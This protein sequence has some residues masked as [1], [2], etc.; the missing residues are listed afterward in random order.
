MSHPDG[1]RPLPIRGRHRPPRHGA[2]AGQPRRRGSL[3]RKGSIFLVTTMVGSMLIRAFLLQAFF[4]PSGSME[5]TLHGCPGCA[6]DRVLVS[7]LVDYV[8]GVHRGD[9][10]TFRDPGGWL[11]HGFAAPQTQ[12]GVNNALVFL[13][14]APEGGAGDLIKRVIGVGG[15]TVEGRS[16]TVYVNGIRLVEP[17]VFP[18]DTSSEID[19]RVTVPVDKLW[20]MGDH[21]S[22]SG[23]SRYQQQAPGKGFVPV[24][25]V[26]GRA[27]AIGSPLSRIGLLN[28]PAT[29]DKIRSAPQH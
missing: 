18:G 27:F 19:F 15:D 7:K 6:G 16:G 21:R 20:V 3:L 11:T 24:K 25:D 12:S 14:L 9:I 22:D 1:D 5:P 26:V 23:D 8:G 29:F 2:A 17:Y 4:I 28:R 10:V 13:G